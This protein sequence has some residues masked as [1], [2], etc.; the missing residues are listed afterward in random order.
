MFKNDGH[1]FLKMLN[2]VEKTF[3]KEKKFI[4]VGG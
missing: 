4:L 3:K 2:K 1:Q